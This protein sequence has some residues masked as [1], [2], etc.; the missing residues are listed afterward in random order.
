MRSFSYTIEIES[1]D[2]TNV[3][4][5][6]KIR[7]QMDNDMKRTYTFQLNIKTNCSNHS[8]FISRFRWGFNQLQDE[9]CLQSCLAQKRK[10]I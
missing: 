9:R 4:V 2:G 5:R 7:I 1:L 10:T 6:R 8:W 3:A